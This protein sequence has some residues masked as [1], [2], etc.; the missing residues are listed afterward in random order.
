MK[1]DR[2]HIR[3]SLQVAEH[4]VVGEGMERS[5]VAVVVDVVRALVAIG[6]RRA[7]LR[8]R[9]VVK[10]DGQ[11]HGNEHPHQQPCC[12]LSSLVYLAH[13]LK[14]PLCPVGH[15]SQN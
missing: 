15:R 9:M 6:C 14:L 1:D 2:R 4:A 11:Q 12:P 7:A 5:E 10:G 3:Q 8:L 13:S